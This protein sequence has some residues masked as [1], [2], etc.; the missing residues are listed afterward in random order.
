MVEP[1]DLNPNILKRVAE[2]DSDAVKQCL[3]KYSRLV[4]SL[5]LRMLGNRTDAEDATQEI[6]ID[7]WKSASRYDSATGNELT[8]ISMI[9]RRRLIDRRRKMPETNEQIS[10]E[11]VDTFTDAQRSNLHELDN[12][13][14][15]AKVRLLLNSLKPEQKTALL[16]SI[17]HGKTHNEIAET[18][19]VPVGTVKTNIRRGLQTIREEHQNLI[20]KGGR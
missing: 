8:F 14:E 6:F 18:L 9:A 1:D 15:A 10:Q 5:S 13:D 17:D 12:R 20:Q 7:I 19:G 11:T 4:Y 16:L 2:G 3:E